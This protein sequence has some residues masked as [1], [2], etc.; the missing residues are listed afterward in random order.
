MEMF[1]KINVTAEKKSWTAPSLEILEMKF[2]MADK[3]WAF[4]FDGDFWKRELI[5]PS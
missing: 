4:G 2:T 5:D 1:E 3:M